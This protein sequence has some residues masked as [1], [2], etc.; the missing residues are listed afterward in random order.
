MIVSTRQRWFILVALPIL[1]LFLGWWRGGPWS[2]SL[3]RRALLRKDFGSAARWL[4]RTERYFGVTTELLLLRAR[5]ARQ[6]GR[7]A[8]CRR[9]LELAQRAGGNDLA[10]LREQLLL[11]AQLGEL[12]GYEA[13]YRQLVAEP[14]DEAF[15]V[16]EAFAIGLLITGRVNESVEIV[17]RW[18]Q[19]APQDAQPHYLL[20]IMQRDI[21]WPG[22]AR[23]EFRAALRLQPD[24]S[25]AALELAVQLT[26]SHQYLEAGPYYAIALRNSLTEPQARVGLAHCQRMVGN[27]Q[28]ARQTLEP[29][30]E[31]PRPNL[32]AMAELGSLEL[33]DGNYEKSLQWTARA[34]AIMPRNSELNY[35]YAAALAA[36]VRHAEANNAFQF[37]I[38]AR[39]ASRRVKNL[40]E[41]AGA[42]ADDPAI[43]VELAQIAREFGD[44]GDAAR[45][46]QRALQQDPQYAPARAL[47]SQ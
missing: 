15:V 22:K 37:A 33:M 44:P 32:G 26:R 36:L 41:I 31:Q 3:A 18:Q 42:H 24:H 5:L 25:Q 27:T 45:W 21:G 9:Q 11:Q 20:G 23:D 6:E 16:H 43:S 12:R 39:R 35:T 13:Y 2:Q 4:D 10:L 29:L 30:I 28:A 14:A 1:L 7:I 8:D 34:R 38:E 17:E 46:T 19:E 47:I 40:T